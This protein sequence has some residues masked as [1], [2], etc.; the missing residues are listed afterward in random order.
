MAKSRE[1]SAR[2]V[3]PI[4]DSVD[5]D[6][7]SSYSEGFLT[8][9]WSRKESGPNLWKGALA[10]AAGGLA[11][12]VAMML[13]Q[14]AWSKGAE[15]AGADDLAGQTHRQEAAQHDATA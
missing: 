1:S 10:G 14:G 13:F 9:D 2:N 12:A 7:M 11:G 5:F 3:Y 4:S 8:P 15:A 6:S